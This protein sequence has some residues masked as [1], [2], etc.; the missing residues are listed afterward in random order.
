MASTVID[1]SLLRS[2]EHALFETELEF[3]KAE[4]AFNASCRAL[5]HHDASRMRLVVAQ[6]RARTRRAQLLDERSYLLRILGRI[7]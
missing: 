1:H 6:D 3:Q 7:K 4:Q 5:E 2:T